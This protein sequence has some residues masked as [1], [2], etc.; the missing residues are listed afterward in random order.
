MMGTMALWGEWHF[1][2]DIGLAFLIFSMLFVLVYH[3]SKRKVFVVPFIVNVIAILIAY[4]FRGFSLLTI[5]LVASLLI[6]TMIFMF[7]NIAS[8]RPLVNN[9]FLSKKQA[10]KQSRYFDRDQLS[11]C[12]VDTVAYL[13]KTK[14][15]A[16]IAIERKSGLSEFIK[17]GSPMNAP[18]SSELLMTI[19]Y[20]GTRLHDGAVVIRDNM[21]IA[22]SVYFPPTTKPLSGKYGSRH[23]A[24]LGISEVSDAVVIVVSEETGRISIAYNGELEPV[25]IDQ[26]KQ[27]FI[28]YM[29]IGQ[30]EKD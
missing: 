11:G 8:L 24:A 10:P 19:F 22:A 12:I 16:I 30:R 1:W 15:G 17:N 6:I 18:V 5:T 26:F 14:T 3:V 13:S 28:H 25:F 7:V 2:L 23:R 29:E 27:L 4:V 9:L 21:I 20:P